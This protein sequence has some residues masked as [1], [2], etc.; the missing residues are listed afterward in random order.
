MV[1]Y[2]KICN[3]VLVNI[4]NEVLKKLVLFKCLMYN[5]V[6]IFINIVWLLN[7]NI[8]VYIVCNF[9]CKV[10]VCLFIVKKI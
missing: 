5:S 9:Y 2:F 1:I 4:N 7:I 8:L 6:F 10:K 3:V